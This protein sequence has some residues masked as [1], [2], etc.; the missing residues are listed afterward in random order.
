MDER[1]R[2]GH[3]FVL[4]LLR[5][6]PRVHDGRPQ[7]VRRLDRAAAGEH[8]PHVAAR[9]LPERLHVVADQRRPL[10]R[11]PPPRVQHV[12]RADPPPRRERP[13]VRLERVQPHPHDPPPRLREPVQLPRQVPLGL[14]V[15]QTPRHGPEHPPHGPQPRE[16]FV[17]KAR[18]QQR[19]VR[20]RRRRRDRQPEQVRPGQDRPVARRVRRQVLQHRRRMHPVAQPQRLVRLRN[21]HPLV[22]LLLDA[23]ER[24]L[25]TRVHREEMH[26]HPVHLVHPRLERVLPRVVALRA[27]RE[28]IHPVAHARRV[29]GEVLQQRL[30][31]ADRPRPRVPRG[32]KRQAL[33][34]RRAPFPAPPASLPARPPGLP[35]WQ[36]APP[37]APRCPGAP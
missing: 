35:A 22:D 30:R 4:L 33:S 12:R 1:H 13:A 28:E 21:L 2:P 32:D 19:L 15:E 24:P 25:V 36:S 31:A 14:R 10:Q 3:R 16:H 18:N 7:R 6:E 27:G 29:D 9:P 20:V 8:H 34:H 37:S 17:M 26:P 11:L 23:Q 5:D